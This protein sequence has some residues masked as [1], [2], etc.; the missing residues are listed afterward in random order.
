M[1][2]TFREDLYYRL[3][4]IRINVPPLRERRGDIP[5]LTLHFLSKFAAL[6]KK[7]IIG[8]SPDAMEVLESYLWPGNVREPRISWK[9]RLSCAD[10]DK[11]TMG[12]LPKEI[13]TAPPLPHVENLQY[14][15]AKE[16]W[17]AAFEKNYLT[18]LLNGTSGNISLQHKM[19]GLTER[20]YTGL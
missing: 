16:A 15:D 1:G 19:Q 18:S 10:A 14:K 5:V 2:E 6:N 9:G 3:N 17:L 7:N 11:I 13:C 12:D 4:V 8:I 20:Q